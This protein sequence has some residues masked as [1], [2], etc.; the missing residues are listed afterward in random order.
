MTSGIFLQTSARW[1]VITTCIFLLSIAFPGRPG[2]Q[3][4]KGGCEVLGFEAFEESQ[5]VLTPSGDYTVTARRECAYVT[6]QNKNDVA[7]EVGDFTFLAVFGNGGLARGR[8]DLANNDV[9]KRIFPGD[10]YNGVI[11][12]DGDSPIRI[13]NCGI[14]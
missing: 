6:I 14:R 1:V 7:I 8:F 12:F 13:L 10:T 9:K 2:A 4:M 5:A 11:C 3:G